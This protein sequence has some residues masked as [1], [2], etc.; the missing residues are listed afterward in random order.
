MISSDAK[1]I[2][3]LI[4]R[5]KLFLGRKILHGYDIELIAI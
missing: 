3:L 2:D 1:I 5:T 4:F